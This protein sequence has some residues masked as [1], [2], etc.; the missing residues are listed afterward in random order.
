MGIPNAQILEDQHT[1]EWLAKRVVKLEFLARASR[2][3]RQA[4]AYELISEDMSPG[5][6]SAYIEMSF[7]LT[8]LEEKK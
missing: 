7:A 1:K 2:R 4:V 5:F 8:N 3:M 6:N